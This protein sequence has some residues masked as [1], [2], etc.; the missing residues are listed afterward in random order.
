MQIFE[1]FILTYYEM[2][3]ENPIRGSEYVERGDYFLTFMGYEFS[4]THGACG[5]SWTD[6]VDELGPVEMGV[7]ILKHET[8]ALPLVLSG[9][10]RCIRCNAYVPHGSRASDGDLQ[11]IW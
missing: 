8:E 5:Y 1:A 2:H 3:T 4:P 9:S 11:F 7:V 6:I 10:N